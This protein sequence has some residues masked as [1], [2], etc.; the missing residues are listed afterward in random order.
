MATE[1]VVERDKQSCSGVIFAIME[2]Y[3]CKAK[4]NILLSERS[5]VESSRN[6]RSVEMATVKEVAELLPNG[7]LSQVEDSLLQQCEIRLM[8]CP[9]NLIS[10]KSYVPDGESNNFFE[11]CF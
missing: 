3:W 11:A 1:R 9:S 10:P 5:S 2:S 6:E 8:I 4:A 7:S